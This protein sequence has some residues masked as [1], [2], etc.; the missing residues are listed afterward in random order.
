MTYQQN[1]PFP[2]KP[3]G[4]KEERRK[5]NKTKYR[6]RNSNDHVKDHSPN[7]IPSSEYILP[8]ER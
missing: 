5:V 7:Y 6:S 3:K 4:K 2:P 8:T 1:F